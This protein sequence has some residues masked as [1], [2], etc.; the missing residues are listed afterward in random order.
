MKVH[1]LEAFV[2]ES[3][4][5]SKAKGYYP[6]EFVRMRARWKT[7]KAIRRL[8]ISGDIQSGFRRMKDLGLLDW[9]LE[10]AVLKFPNEFDAPVREAA[11]WRLDQARD[12]R[13]SG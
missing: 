2:D 9:A 10:A 1:D 11:R 4:R 3:I 6:S 12:A 7:K 13:H 5:R 8:V